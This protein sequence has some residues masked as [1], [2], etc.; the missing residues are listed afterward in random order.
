[1]EEV[2]QLCFCYLSNLSSLIYLVIPNQF[3]ERKEIL[4]ERLESIPSSKH[5]N[6]SSTTISTTATA[7][8]LPASVFRPNF[9]PSTT[10]LSPRRRKP[11]FIMSESEVA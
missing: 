8:L 3:A 9:P 2:P 5:T 10:T 1:M 11:L 6:L 4:K 7:V